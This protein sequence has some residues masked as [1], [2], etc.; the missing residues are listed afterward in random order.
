MS[1]KITLAIPFNAASSVET[2]L[3]WVSIGSVRK[4]DIIR[5]TS[6]SSEITIWVKMNGI[7]KQ[8]VNKLP[9]GLSTTLRGAYP[10]PPNIDT[11]FTIANFRGKEGTIRNDIT[12]TFYTQAGVLESHTGVMYFNVWTTE[13]I[14]V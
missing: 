8:T 12:L 14:E 5:L 13:E 4:V 6:D 9:S 1:R 3:S 11:E 7:P 10:V 2:D